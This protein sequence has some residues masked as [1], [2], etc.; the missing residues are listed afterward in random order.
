[1]KAKNEDALKAVLKQV[2][3]RSKLIVKFALKWVELM[4]PQ[5][6]AGKKLV[7]VAEQANLD[8]DVDGMSGH[9]QGIAATFIATHWIY[10]DDFANWFNTTKGSP[11]AAK[12]AKRRII[13]PASFTIE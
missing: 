11:K 7:D 6:E 12:K 5:I 8:A 1:M 2:S 4:E 9:A 3:S 13:D 10:G